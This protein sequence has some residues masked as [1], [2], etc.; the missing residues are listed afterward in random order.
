[1]TFG[2]D[3]IINQCSYSKSL[4]KKTLRCNFELYENHLLFP[5]FLL[6][7]VINGLYIKIPYPLLKD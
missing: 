6:V 1:M 3:S 4:N 5:N 7:L 2:F